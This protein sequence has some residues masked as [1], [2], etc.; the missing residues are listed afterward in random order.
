MCGTNKYILGNMVTNNNNYYNE[1]SGIFQKHYGLKYTGSCK[2]RPNF[3]S[4]IKNLYLLTEPIVKNWR[5]IQVKNCKPTC[6]WIWLCKP[7][8]TYWQ[9]E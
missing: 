3:I 6:V 9:K 5:V 7:N 4:L 2:R 8:P 1:G